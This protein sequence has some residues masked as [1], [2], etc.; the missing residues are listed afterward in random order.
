MLNALAEVELI[1]PDEVTATAQEIGLMYEG[2][3]EA[4]RH[5]A[6]MGDGPNPGPEV[7]KLQQQMKADLRTDT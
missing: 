5:G 4:T 7:V 3:I 2:Y 1:A 6:K